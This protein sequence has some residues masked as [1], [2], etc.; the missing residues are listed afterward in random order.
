VVA[1]V[2]KVILRVE[3]LLDQVVLVLSL[4]EVI[5]LPHTTSIDLYQKDPPKEGLNNYIINID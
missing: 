4:F 2:D 5:T 1:E 3:L